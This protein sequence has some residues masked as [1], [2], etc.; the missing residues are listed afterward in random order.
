MGEII[1]KS[2]GIYATWKLGASEILTARSV[3][4]YKVLLF[5]MILFI[6]V[7]WFL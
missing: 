7:I 5:R 3:S 2:V 4:E 1:I 6:A